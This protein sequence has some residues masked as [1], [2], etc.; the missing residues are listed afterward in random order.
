MRLLGGSARLAPESVLDEKL[1]FLLKLAIGATGRAGRLRPA[2]VAQLGASRKHTAHA[3]AH[4]GPCALVPRLLL[5]PDEVLRAITP[6][7]LFDPVEREGM[8]LLQ[9]NQGHVV[10]GGVLSRRE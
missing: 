10:E 4:E 7:D 1:R 9:P 6:Q 3:I 5:N 2:H 8:D